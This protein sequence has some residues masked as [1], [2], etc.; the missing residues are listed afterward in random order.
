MSVV[1]VFA[2]EIDMNAVNAEEEFRWGV[3]AFHSGLY[4]ESVRAFER[5][6]AFTPE[7]LQI[8]E[9]L[10]NAY[11]RSGYEETALSI[12]DA[13]LQSGEGTPLL[14]NL[15]ETARA[16]R[17]LDEELADELRYVTAFSLSGEQPNFTLFSR[18]A[19]VFQR[20]DGS[21]LLTSFAGNQVLRLSANGALKQKILGG[22]HG[23]DHPFDVVE[24]PGR[25][26]FISEFLGNSIVRT[27]SSGTDVFRFGKKGTGKG[28][29]IGPQF[30]TV[31]ENGYL[32]VAETGNRR[33]SKFD[34]DGNFI[35]SFGTRN[36]SF[37]GI[38]SPTG[39]CVHSGR[40]Y[41]ADGLDKVIHIFDVSGNYFAS[42]GKDELAGPEGLSV[43]SD[44]RLL[45]ADGVRVLS[46]DV[47]TESFSLIS[48]LDGEGRR[49][50]KAVVDVNGDLV[51]TDF[52]GN[53]VTMLT[54][55]SNIYTGLFVQVER[56]LSD[57]FPNVYL[58]LSVEDRLG[59]AYLGLD[60]SNFIISESRGRVANDSYLNQPEGE[61]LSVALLVDR[62]NGMES[63]GA[64][65]SEAASGVYEY[66]SGHEGLLTL[67]SGGEEP[68][69]EGD[70][71]LGK[72]RF[73]AIAGGGEF[74]DSTRFSLALRLAASEVLSWPGLSAVVYLTNGELGA[75]A[76]DDYSLEVLAA[77]LRNN[78]VAFY[79]IYLQ[80]DPSNSGELEYLCDETNGSSC[81]LY[82]R[83]GLRPLLEE[84][85]G[86]QTGRYFFSYESVQNTRFGERFLSVE[87]EVFHFQRSGRAESGYF[88][89]RE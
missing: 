43:Y 29:L 44:S 40:V 51:V 9:W 39:I 53:T 34:Y 69:I 55:V 48:D 24:V 84:M 61:L 26:I 36:G 59:N 79:C 18:P 88:A 81:Y 72:Q 76:F 37:E 80:P 23:L 56:V 3:K 60:E 22:I 19:S 45:V 46:Y 10:G 74:S 75:S 7:D 68:A 85:N 47:V 42:I 15:V 2:Q 50:T 30:M 52:T 73:A 66:V 49:I 87:V 78:G 4:G 20:D 32:Y 14:R 82:G 89:P 64:S 13:V 58:E 28:E 62:S 63:F 6:L 41:V 38:K 77:Y 67:V 33:V 11:Y 86:R 21:F 25:Y 5:A 71:G 17:G 31:D 1:S 83:E 54:D 35:L 16:R 70:S 12:W 65:T 27:N 8:Q 57:D